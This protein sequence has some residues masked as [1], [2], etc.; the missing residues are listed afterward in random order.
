MTC[1]AEKGS[2]E[3]IGES[4][5]R[6]IFAQPKVLKAE[7]YFVYFPLSELHGWGKRFAASRRRFIQRFPEANPYNYRGG[8]LPFFCPNSRLILNSNENL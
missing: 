3:K 8:F 5:R 7:E 6:K 2:S 4:W 1:A